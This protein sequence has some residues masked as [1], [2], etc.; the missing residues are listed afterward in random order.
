MMMIMKG[1]GEEYT[2]MKRK[3]GR[4]QKKMKTKQHH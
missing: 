4:S 3:R 1:S 2:Q